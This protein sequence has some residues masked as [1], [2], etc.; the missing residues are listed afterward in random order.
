MLLVEHSFGVTD[1]AQRSTS[2]CWYADLYKSI[3]LKDEDEQVAVTAAAIVAVN[4]T[5]FIDKVSH[6]AQMLRWQIACRFNNTTLPSIVR[7]STSAL[8]LRRMMHT[9][10][11]VSSHESFISLT[12][13]HRCSKLVFW[14]TAE[15]YKPS[16]IQW[17]IDVSM[18]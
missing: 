7:L 4:R 3:P 18:I 2:V 10:A 16:A 13:C 17:K 1:I 6:H 15:I 9:R 11:S 8:A 14:F 5:D 12:R